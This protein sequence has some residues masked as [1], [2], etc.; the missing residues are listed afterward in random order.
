MF[1]LLPVWI[2]RTQPRKSN[3]PICMSKGEYVMGRGLAHNERTR[4]ETMV[5]MQE[6]KNLAISDNNRPVLEG[7]YIA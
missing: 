4:M 7:I 3:W 5:Q 2:S 6:M 1:W